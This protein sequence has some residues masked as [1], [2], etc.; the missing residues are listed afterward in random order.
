MIK[1]FT[2]RV[3]TKSIFQVALAL[4]SLSLCVYFVKHEGYHLKQS[5]DLMFNVP[6]YWVLSGLMVTAI[7]L[8]VHGCMYMCS[9]RTVGVKPTFGSTVLLSLKRS[10]ISVFLPAGGISSLA[11]FTGPIEQQGI[12]R[13]KIHLSSTVYGITGFISL[14]LIAIPAIV[15]L[16][17]KH[18]LSRE[19]I[20]SFLFLILLIVGVIFF[21]VFFFKNR[22]IHQ[23]LVRLSPRMVVF[24][25]EL[26]EQK[27][28]L[29]SFLWTVFFSFLI[30]LCGVAHLYISMKAFQIPAASIEIALVGYVVATLMYALS[31]FLRGLGAVEIT[32]SLVLMQYGVPSIMALSI[33]FLYRLFEFWIPLLIGAL[34][35]ISRKDHLVLRILPPFFTLMVGLV[36]VLSVL[37]PAIAGRMKFLHSFLSKDAIYVSNFAVVISG[38]VLIVLSSYLLR[39][40][41]NAWLATI[42][43]TLVSFVGNLTKAFDFEE[44]FLCLALI[45]L[46][47]YT[48]KNYRLRTDQRVTPTVKAYLIAGLLFILS[49]G[50]IGYYLIDKRHFGVDLNLGQSIVS[51]FSTL[52]FIPL[53]TPK[54]AFATWFEDSINI[55]GVS[56]MAILLLILVRPLRHRNRSHSEEIEEAKALL[57]KYGNSQL[58]YFKIYPDKNLYWTEDR[59]AFVSF[60]IAY[61]YAVVLE[62]PVCASPDLLPDLIDSFDTYCEKNGLK[63]IYYRIDESCLPYFEQL[64]KKSIFIGQEGI[65]DVTSFSLEGRSRR[66]IRNALNKTR[67]NG[68]TCHVV[69]PPIKEGLLQKMKAVSMEWLELFHKKESAFSQGVWN[70]EEIKQ[71]VVFLVEDNEEK[72]VAFANLV[73]DYAKGEG[74]Y[75]LIRKTKDAPNGVLDVL[76]VNMIEYMKAKGLQSLN[77]GLAPLSGMDKARDLKEK[78]VKFAYS[79]IKVLEHYKGLRFFKEKYADDWKSKYMIYNCDY[80]LIQSPMVIAKVSKYVPY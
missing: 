1:V 62:T 78:S 63:T 68:Y 5:V 9:F 11:F 57:E 45:G 16:L 28:S 29:R 53:E 27:Y 42:Y 43:I 66:P 25:E 74:T 69:E 19:L 77:L 73:P 21:I 39:G 37:T 38:I 48:R 64:K 23:L 41:R 36:N 71:Q 13:T 12:S 47:I 8:F 80:D 44:A 61:D 20:Y 72:V 75:D 70:P 2:S 18:M 51:L 50:I 6:W 17:F 4:V 3:S 49:Y 33:A 55:L 65:A 31:P 24:Y 52:L 46:L 67:D 59:Q 10:F 32:L 56:Y 58:D 34:S 30:E 79:N 60:K 76:V 14:A 35:F 40:F 54:T 26:K 22:K 7:Y 15:V